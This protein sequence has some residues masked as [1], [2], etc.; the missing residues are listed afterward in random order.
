MGHFL[1]EVKVLRGGYLRRKK[2]KRE[3][4]RLTKIGVRKKGSKSN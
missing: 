4:G 2:E 3:K 1:R